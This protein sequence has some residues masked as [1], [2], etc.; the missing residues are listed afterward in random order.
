MIALKSVHL[1]QCLTLLFGPALLSLLLIVHLCV[2]SRA[3]KQERRLETTN[4]SA[5]GPRAML[6]RRLRRVAFY[7]AKG[8]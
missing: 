1:Q 7:A 2:W 8:P 6:P 5:H 4:S 3:R